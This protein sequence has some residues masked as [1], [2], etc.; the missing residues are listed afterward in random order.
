MNLKIWKLKDQDTRSSIFESTLEA[1]IYLDRQLDVKNS[2]LK[3][4]DDLKIHLKK[5]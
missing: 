5:S 3:R 1:K 2:S 4:S